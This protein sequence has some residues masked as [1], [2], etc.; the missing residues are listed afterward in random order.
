M[1]T[2]NQRYIAL[3]GGKLDGKTSNRICV[4]DMKRDTEWKMKK[5]KIECPNDGSCHVIRTGGIGSKDHL[6]VIGYIRQCFDSTQFE[7]IQLPP[8]YIMMMIIERFSSERIHWIQKGDH[9]AIY[10]RDLLSSLYV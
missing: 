1:L 3:F 7:N 9:F 2:S 8:T 4:L 6:L 5:S 10:L